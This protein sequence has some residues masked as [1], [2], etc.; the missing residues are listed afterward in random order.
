MLYKSKD[1]KSGLKIEINKVPYI[2]LECKFV[3]PGKGQA[4]NKLKLKNLINDAVIIKT[5]KIGERLQSTD[6]VSKDVKFLYRNNDIFCFIDI[7]SSEYY[8][9]SL[10]IINKNEGWIKNDIVY[11]IVFWNNDIIA[12]KVP[13]F[14]ELQVI[15]TEDVSK[16]STITKSFKTA[17]LE[18]KVAFKV[19]LFVRKNDIIKINTENEE[20]VSRL[21]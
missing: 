11:S 12:F 9:V 14:I 5:V 1:L 13:K 18:T 21:N 4:F 20:Y 10:K 19:P 8:D 2:I 15:S 7:E 17:I 6:I 3:N 16:T